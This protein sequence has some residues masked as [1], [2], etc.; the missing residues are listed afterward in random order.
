MATGYS[1]LAF[2][3]GACIA[4]Q[5]AMNSQLA[6]QLQ[7]V[8][9]ATSYA[10]F[11]S[12]VLTSILAATLSTPLPAK[13]LASTPWYL[14]FSF[15]LSVVGVASMYF[16]I[17]KLGAGNAITIALCGQVIFALLISHFGWFASPV[18][19]LTLTKVSGLI[20][21]LLGLYL[22]NRTN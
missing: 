17:P 11:A 18:K 1:L 15:I 13:A 19:Y 7:S 12:F 22:I 8:L 16:L 2:I 3:C 20:F 9:K 4:L 14:W 21:M 5:A 6:I 10:F